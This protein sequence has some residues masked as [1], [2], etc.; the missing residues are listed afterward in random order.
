M[1][2][3]RIAPHIIFMFILAVFIGRPA[4]SSA[5]A[6]MNAANI[7][8]GKIGVEIIKQNK[9]SLARKS[10][11]ITTQDKLK[12]YTAPDFESYTYLISS[13]KKEA[14]LLSPSSK[15]HV[16]ATAG[17]IKYPGENQFYQFDENSDVESL[18][19]ICSPNELKEV[20][21]LFNS[22]TV[23]HA[24]WVAVEKGLIEK[25]KVL[26]SKDVGKEV[27]IGGFIQQGF[28]SAGSFID[29]IPVRKGN[30]LLIKKYEFH[31][32]NAKK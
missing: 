22:E 18:T 3:Y 28:R 20:Q 4:L 31:V 24:S 13:N 23:S 16:K 7:V 30:F 27:Q 11:R 17:L 15:G 21:E 6:K 32:Y 29:K 1:T 26:V 14:T 8:K 12:V 10:N 19:I 9:S 25:S 2:I 5:D